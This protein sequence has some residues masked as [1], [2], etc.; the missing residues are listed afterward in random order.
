M[1][2]FVFF[3]HK[4]ADEMRIRDWS[5]DVCSA[6]LLSCASCHLDRGREPH[7]APMW[8]AYVIYPKDRSKNKQINTMEDRLRGCFTYS[9]NGQDAPSGGPPPAGHPIYKDL[10]M[11]FHWLASGAPVG[12]NL[13]IGRAHV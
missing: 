8:A 13:Q 5:S 12:E 2:F 10:Q 7:S 11:Y 6:D 1:P 3:M 4:T 9:M